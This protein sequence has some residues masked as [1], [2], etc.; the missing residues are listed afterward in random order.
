MTSE[1]NFQIIKKI[2]TETAKKE[3]DQ[4]EKENIKKEAVT[5]ARKEKAA[6][7]R[8]QKKLVIKRIK[9]NPKLLTVSLETFSSIL[10]DRLRWK[11]MH[12]VTPEETPVALVQLKMV[13]PAIKWC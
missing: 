10:P 6:I 5:K 9:S 4:K 8:K 1:E 3:A 2:E 13:F 7:K 11:R 12:H